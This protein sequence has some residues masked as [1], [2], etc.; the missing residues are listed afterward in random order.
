[1]N[2]ILTLI[3]NPR[4]A[5]ICDDT[6]ALAITSLNQLGAKTAATDWLAHGI[7]CDIPFCGIDPQDAKATIEQNFHKLP[8][9]FFVQ[10]NRNRRKKLLVSD[11]DSTMVLGETLDDLA[12]FAG[13]KNQVATI[14][15][16]AMNGELSFVDA[17][18]K[19]VKLLEGLSLDDLK[20]TMS[21]IKYTPGG[22]ILV[23][24]MK[25]NGAFTIL[26]SG[27]FTYFTERVGDQIG[28]DRTI[29]NN[30]EISGS[31]LTGQVLEPIIDKHSKLEVLKNTAA[32][33]GISEVDTIAVGDGAND[34]PMLM[35]AD[36]GVAFHAKPKVSKAAHVSIKHGDLTALL[37]IQGYRQNEFVT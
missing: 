17:L 6:C 25:A 31:N 2:H 15:S 4:T 13:F 9:D 3:C 21:G 35:A 29:G 7:A 1:M 18:N 27:G 28:F 37:Y 20:T 11:M 34:L 14:T 33:F 23:Q 30:F 12:D 8:I 16:L 32:E 26:I 22:K 36:I 5:V 24:T 19:R 10:K